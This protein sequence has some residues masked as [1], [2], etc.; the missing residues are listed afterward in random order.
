MKSE[1]GGRKSEVGGRR[2]EVGSRRAEVGGRKSEVGSRKSEVGSR[3]A[4]GVKGQ[5][6]RNPACPQGERRNIGIRNNKKITITETF[7][8]NQSTMRRC[9]GHLVIQISDLFRISY[10]VFRVY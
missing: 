4:E 2:S 1:V 7:Q 8:Q 3:R 6:I 5:K 10:F 9:F